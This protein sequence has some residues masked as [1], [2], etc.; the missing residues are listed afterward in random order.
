MFLHPYPYS[1]VFL[2]I[3]FTLL[4]CIQSALANE[5]KSSIRCGV[6]GYST[7]IPSDTYYLLATENRFKP[8]VGVM[9]LSKDGQAIL[10]PPKPYPGSLSPKEIT[11]ELAKAT[12]GKCRNSDDGSF[13][14]F[15]L[16]TV[17]VVDKRQISRLEI[18][19]KFIKDSLSAYR[20]RSKLI[21]NPVWIEVK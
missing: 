12:W 6:N 7:G 15:D 21:E 11:L 20:L 2:V 14:T 1:S 8:K 10:N 16:W 9:R 4:V 5:N 17:S 13:Y 3:C 18:D 19:A